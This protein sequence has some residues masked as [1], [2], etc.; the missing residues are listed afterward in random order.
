MPHNGRSG[1]VD[2]SSPASGSGTEQRTDAEWIAGGR[3]TAEPQPVWSAYLE[4]RRLLRRLAA[5]ALAIVTLSAGAAFVGATIWPETSAARAEL[6]YPITQE[7]PTGFLRED[8][9]MTTQ[10]VL[11]QS[12]PVL[13]GVALEHGRSVED[14][15]RQLSATVLDDSEII[16]LEVTDRSPEQALLIL[17]AVVDSYLEFNQSSRPLLRERLEAEVAALNT[18]LA[19]AQSEL[20][21]QQE[22]VSDGTEHAA[23]LVP[24]QE[25]VQEQQ[26][27]LR[28]LQAQL[29]SINFAPV[30]QL[31]TAP[32]AAGV[33][34]PQPALAAATG[35]LVG[36]LLA[37][38][39]VAVV[40][41]SRAVG[42]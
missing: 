27:R 19:T 35:G 21:N 10:L 25:T 34:H 30:A 7:Q 13:N 39:L 26:S 2:Q 24:L 22:L 36:V 33:V 8:R 9:N 15:Q 23:T 29:D 18:E 40:A 1:T 5:L 42:K 20:A 32:Y 16:E 14:L 3:D 28:Q 12:R 38:V 6:I 11:I 17:Q 31:L 4:R 37:A 41:R